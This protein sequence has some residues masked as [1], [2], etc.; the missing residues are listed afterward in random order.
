MGKNL[1]PDHHGKVKLLE[2]T[3]QQKH[4]HSDREEGCC[5]NQRRLAQVMGKI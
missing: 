5:S 2:N 3:L 1:E 4:I